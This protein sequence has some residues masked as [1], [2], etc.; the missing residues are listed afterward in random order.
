MGVIPKLKENP[1]NQ[2]VYAKMKKAKM[3]PPPDFCGAEEVI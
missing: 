3:K 1:I 2:E